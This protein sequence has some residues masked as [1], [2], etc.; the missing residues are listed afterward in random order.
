[1]SSI[2]KLHNEVAIGG[3]PDTEWRTWAVTVS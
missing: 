2:T 3:N 1:M